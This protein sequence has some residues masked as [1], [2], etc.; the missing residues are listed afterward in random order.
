M[1]NNTQIR[2]VTDAL[3]ACFADHEI[4]EDFAFEGQSF[5]LRCEAWALHSLEQLE[6]ELEATGVGEKEDESNRSAEEQVAKQKT[7]EESFMEEMIELSE[8]LQEIGM[9]RFRKLVLADPEVRDAAMTLQRGME[10]LALP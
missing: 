9:E 10:E 7:N 8:L 6:D 1:N 5:I 4:P 2:K 3:R